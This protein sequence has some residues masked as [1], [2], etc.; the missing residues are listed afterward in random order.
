MEEL[1]KMADEV[2]DNSL[3]PEA[4]ESLCWEKLAGI[5]DPEK[6]QE[7]CAGLE[8]EVPATHVGKRN[9]VYKLLLKHLNSDTIAASEDQGMSTFLKLSD[10]LKDVSPNVHSPSGSD[11]GSE[12]DKPKL[13]N[14]PKI[15]HYDDN[16]AFYHFEKLKE[17][18]IN[19]KIGGVGEKDKLSY[20]SLS[21]QISNAKKLGYSEE[22]I[23]GAV[24]KAI[25]PGN[26]LR[27][28]LESKHLLTLS[29]LIEIMRS[30]FR[31]KD[32]SSVFSELSN[33]AQAANESC[34]DFVIRLMCLREK[35]VSLSEEE[36]C[37]YDRKLVGQRFSHTVLTGLRNNNIRNDL[38]SFLKRKS[39]SDEALLKVV[40]EA[41]TNETEHFEKT[42]KKNAKIN[43]IAATA[44]QENDKSKKGKDTT[45]SPLPQQIQEI[46]LLHEREMCAVKNELKEIK[47]LL[48]DVRKS[49]NVENYRNKPRKSFKRKCQNCYTTG[50]P[51]CFHCFK[52]GSTEHRIANC[53]GA[54]NEQ[55]L[56]R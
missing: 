21:Y 56:P 5:T 43:V 48:Y 4:V 2:A 44:E 52:C 9:L 39:F 41:V 42:E 10:L 20:I 50:V 45:Q 23:C 22:M 36:G 17:L 29:S 6:L 15:D 7:I 13:K 49:E 11:S 38:R 1:I 18:K 8:V 53:P 35:V 19:G 34:L 14:E 27:T 55:G 54:G 46:K 40:S 51:T 16:N 32:S 30:H 33:A 37:P 25:M 28:Y 12:R 3:A 26:H 31:E 47:T 24:I